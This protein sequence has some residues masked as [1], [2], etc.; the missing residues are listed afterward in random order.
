MQCDQFE[1]RVNELLDRRAALESDSALMAHSFVCTEC[2]EVLSG[3]QTLVASIPLLDIEDGEIEAADKVL[4]IVTPSKAR[5]ESA[6]VWYW[7]LAV[8]AALVLSVLPWL[9]RP[10]DVAGSPAQ[11]AVSDLVERVPESDRRSQEDGTADLWTA[12]PNEQ[13]L[14][15]AEELA[16]R[17]LTWVEPVADGLRPVTNSMSAALNALRRTLPGSQSATTSS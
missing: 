5:V 2:A 6:Y 12:P 3:Y 9:S 15:M 13:Y 4:S 1:S 7:C 11:P 16:A 8:A 14:A 10:L 17:Q